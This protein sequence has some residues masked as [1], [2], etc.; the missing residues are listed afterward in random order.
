MALATK[1][2]SRD[3][4]NF[5][6]SLTASEV[7]SLADD[8]NLRVL[9]TSTPIESPTWDLLNEGLFA[10]RPDVELRVFG[11]YS[12]VCDLSFLSQVRNVRHFSADCLMSA[13]G[14]GNLSELTALESLSIGIYD[15]QSFD[16]LA[17]LPTEQVRKL[18]LGATKSKKP[19]LDVLEQF[20]R[21]QVLHVEGHEKEIEVISSLSL[22]EDLTLRSLASISINFL[23]SLQHLRSLD[24]KLGGIR[25]LSALDGMDQ[26][27]Y[28]ELWQIKGLSDI[29]V[30]ST[31]IGLQ[32]LFLQSLRNVISIP[33]LSRLTY[34][35]RIYLENMK[36]LEDIR[37]L[38]SAPALE[39]FVH[40]S[41]TGME[42]QCYEELLKIA[43]LNAALV[44]F[45]SDKK[46]TV[47]RQLAAKYGVNEYSHHDFAFA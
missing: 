28:L 36:G 44:G 40:V 3:R 41:A 47:F 24:I 6:D 13:V 31:M 15:L 39:E 1:R 35:R 11:F 20:K 12:T 4:A 17:D 45:G 43:S 10:S 23:R 33:D 34:L 19:S 8:L 42:P 21:V 37:L 46:N 26:I 27:K 7:A 22:L 25:D 5:Y 18:S 9:Q 2:L 14:I 38:S 32:Y 29:S 30:I 16:F